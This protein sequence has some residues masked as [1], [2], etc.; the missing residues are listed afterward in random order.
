MRRTMSHQ[1]WCEPKEENTPL[2]RTKSAPAWCERRPIISFSTSSTPMTAGSPILTRRL[3]RLHI[4]LCESG[5]DESALRRGISVVIARS[6]RRTAHL[7]TH[8]LTVD[9]WLLFL[10]V[11]FS[12]LGTTS[13]YVLPGRSGLSDSSAGRATSGTMGFDAVWVPGPVGGLPVVR[14]AAADVRSVPW[15][16]PTDAVDAPFDLFPPQVVDAVAGTVAIPQEATA[17]VPVDTSRVSLPSRTS[18]PARW[19]KVPE[20]ERPQKW[21]ETMDDDSCALQ[22][23]ESAT[24]VSST[25]A[26]TGAIAASLD[27]EGSA[28]PQ[29]HV[30]IDPAAAPEPRQLR[31]SQELAAVMAAPWTG[32][33]KVVFYG[34]KGC[35]TCHALQPKLQRL[36]AKARAEFV[37]M[38]YGKD[39]H[40]AYAQQAITHT[41]TVNVYD[42]AGSLVDSA[43]YA[44]RDVNKFATVLASVVAAAA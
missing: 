6:S 31:S 34:A 42:G 29:V 33:P 3:P 4:E 22:L 9:A 37:F 26:P 40:E 36:A 21:R 24:A 20:C 2:R 7:V 11:C 17:T 39:T 15:T 19:L 13:G 27:V 14:R 5:E 18:I 35:R 32:I 38:H 10:A 44:P 23:I 25:G 41:P 8:R 1:P 28:N 12:L 16:T 30:T 43:A